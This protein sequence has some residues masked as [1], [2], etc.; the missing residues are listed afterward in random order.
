MD[1]AALYSAGQLDCCNEIQRTEKRNKPLYDTVGKRGGDTV[2]FS[3][4]ALSLAR[5]MA[6]RKAAEAEKGD[7]SRD[8]DGGAAGETGAKDG[9]KTVVNGRLSSEEDLYAEIHRVEKEVQELSEKLM[10]IMEGPA[11]MEEKVLE[12]A[13]VHKRLQERTMDLQSLKAQAEGLKEAR[14]AGAEEEKI[15]GLQV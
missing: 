6:A 11:G 14:A 12:S 7:T 1:I 3:E 8:G 10:E 2:S 4:E 5:D 13:P 15:S 9:A